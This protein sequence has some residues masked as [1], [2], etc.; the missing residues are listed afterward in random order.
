V[1]LAQLRYTE[2]GIR[3]EAAILAGFFRGEQKVHQNLM[4]GLVGELVPL[5]QCDSRGGKKVRGDV[6]EGQVA[7]LTA[8]VP[9]VDEA[10]EK[11]QG[12]VK[13]GALLR[14]GGR[15]RYKDHFADTS[16]AIAL[17]VLHRARGKDLQL[18]ASLGEEHEK[19]AVEIAQRFVGKLVAVHLVAGGLPFRCG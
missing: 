16:Q 13:M 17:V 6:A 19:D 14:R 10:E 1:D 5:D 15:W 18:R 2:G 4:Q 3:D 8:L 9:L 12:I 7:V 11:I